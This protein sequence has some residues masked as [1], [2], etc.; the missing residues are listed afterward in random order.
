MRPFALAALVPLVAGL[1][2]AAPAFATCQGEGL[3]ECRIGKK[4]LEICRTGSAVSYRFGPA[5]KPELEIATALSDLQY[6]PWPGV[7][8]AIWEAVTFHNDGTSYEV[9]SS[10]DRQDPDA[11]PE[12]GVNVLRGE[13][14]IAALDCTKGSVL[15]GL[16]LLYGAKESVG[17]CWSFE[18]HRWTTAPCN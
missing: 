10:F 2:T 15:S 3:F 6:Q 9:W 18:H 1:L 14:L 16:D 13:K 12:G 5:G 8:R 7:G 17:Q 11:K 4:A